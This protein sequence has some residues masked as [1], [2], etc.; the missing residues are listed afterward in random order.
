MD[1]VPS[2]AGRGAGPAPGSAE[3]SALLTANHSVSSL[4]LL[5][6]DSDPKI[7]TLAAAALAAKGDPRLLRRLGPLLE[8]QA[9]TFDRVTG[10]PDITSMAPTYGSQ[11]V[12]RAALELA[13]KLNKAEFD[14]YWANHANLE[15][16]A[17]WFLWQFRHGFSPLARQQILQVPLPDREMAILW[18]GTGRQFQYVG[19]SEAEVLE[20]A[21]ALGADGTLAILSHHPPGTDPD[22]TPHVDFTSASYMRYGEMAR[23]LLSHAKDLLRPSDADVLLRLEDAERSQKSSREPA[24]GAWWPIAAASLRP[25]NAASIL[26]RA[27]QRYPEAY[28][29]P[30]ARW[31]IRGPEA[32]PEILRWFYRSAE[33]Q[34]R[35]TW[36]ILVDESKDRYKR[37]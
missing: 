8:D 10:L 22:I 1:Y 15:Y 26:D 35:L 20:A 36:A 21:R 24:Y 6:K 12:A 31:R 29:I 17:D 23:F 18:I 9:L 5:L 37:S 34:Q 2:G 27:E 13:E 32:L 3:Y 25:Q 16:C 19:Y 33:A 30:L 7:R 11:T 28:E 14:R 4:L